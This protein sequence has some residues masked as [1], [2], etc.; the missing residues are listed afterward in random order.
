MQPG[1]HA[2]VQQAL[3]S[4][5]APRQS[6]VVQHFFVARLVADGICARQ[7]VA[8]SHVVGRLL[9]V[10]GTWRSFLGS[11]LTGIPGYY[12]VM[13]AFAFDCAAAVLINIQMHIP[14]PLPPPLVG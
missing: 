9:V 8:H 5:C 4:Y 1:A 14:P 13:L 2:T 6:L 12:Q 7:C 10:A 3:H 11:G